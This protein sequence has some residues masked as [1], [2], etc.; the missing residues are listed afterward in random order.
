MGRSVRE[1]TSEIVVMQAC[2]FLSLGYIEIFIIYFLLSV[3]E[4][5]ISSKHS[6]AAN[7]AFLRGD[8]ISAHKYS[9]K[10][11]DERMVAE[12]LN[13][14]AAEEIL[15]I[16]NSNNGIW[17]LDLH[18]LHAT[19]AVS[20]L[21]EHLQKIESGTLLNRSISSDALT[22]LEVGIPC[23]S[24][25]GCISGMERNSETKRKIELPHQRQMILHVITGRELQLYSPICSLNA[26]VLAFEMKCVIYLAAGLTT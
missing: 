1:T 10:A 18:G 26:Y 5:R 21:K 4:N 6:R 24:S 3:I 22:K 8:H 13:A 20:A 19:E 12:K 14:S 11:R 17:K 25:S 9:L 7:N 16:R 23:S 15:R 2:H